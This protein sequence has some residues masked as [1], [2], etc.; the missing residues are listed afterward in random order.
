MA[1]IQIEIGHSYTRYEAKRR[2]KPSV[3]KAATSFGLRLR[4]NGDICKFQGPA[5]G[6][7][8]IKDDSVEMAADLG[9]VAMIFRTTIE[10]RIRKKLYQALA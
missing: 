7:I 5:R 9:F 4:W 2:I 1:D 10:K 8:A 3:Q 6:Y